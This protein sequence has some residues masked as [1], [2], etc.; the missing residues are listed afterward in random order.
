MESQICL[1]A[2]IGFK[3]VLILL[4]IVALGSC[5]GERGTPAASVISGNDNP[6][7]AEWHTE[8]VV[9]P[10]DLISNEHYLPAFR[11]AMTRHKAEIAAIAD[12]PDAPTFANTVEAL[13]R[14]GAL[15]T[16]VSSVF[17][18][19]NGANTNDTLQEVDRILAPEQAAHADEISLNAAL[20]QRVKAV[21]DQRA[22]LGL[23]PEQLKLLEETHKDFVRAG[24]A[25][26]DAGKAR[27]KEINAELA[28]LS[29]AFG[30][31]VLAE[32]NAY[33]LHV[34]DTTD[35]GNLSDNLVALAAEEARRRDHD[36]GWSFT[37][38][39]PSINPFLESSP[40]RELRRQ[41]F[42]GY[43]MRGTTTTRT[44][45]RG[46]CRRWRP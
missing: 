34:T 19:V 42:M 17:N 44:T 40:N 35:L 23:T 3:P 25:L 21:Y 22:D 45:T 15:Y 37:L 11:E 27:M 16:R 31:H 29:Q 26:D 6:L 9:P 30:Q 43:A 4:G 2:R 46:F 38:Q 8:F 33:E 12:Q 5:A 28:G 13:E 14:A 7:L 20:Y 18:A 36:G 39:R 1:F 32:T 24:A 10:F 41:L